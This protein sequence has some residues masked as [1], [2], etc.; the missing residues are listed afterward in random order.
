MIHAT[1]D[2][3]DDVVSMGAAG[4]GMLLQGPGNI[5]AGVA[6]R[7]G[8]PIFLALMLMVFVAV[9]PG[10]DGVFAVPTR[11]CWLR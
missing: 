10:P 6:I 4:L 7:E 9:L 1:A 3:I 5:S 11:R 8:M 2:V